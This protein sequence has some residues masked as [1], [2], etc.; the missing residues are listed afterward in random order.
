[1]IEQ[2]PENGV[3]DE[4]LHSTNCEEPDTES[5][6]IPSSDQCNYSDSESDTDMD[7]TGST[8]HEGENDSEHNAEHIIHLSYQ[9]HIKNRLKWKQYIA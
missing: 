1:M 4:L 9:Y 5:V 8:V 2:L 3:P 6:R 7:C